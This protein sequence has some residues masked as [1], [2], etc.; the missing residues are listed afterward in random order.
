MLVCHSLPWS[1]KH[2]QNTPCHNSLAV[3]SFLMKY[4]LATIFSRSDFGC[5]MAHP[6][7]QDRVEGHCSASVKET[8]NTGPRTITEYLHRC[9][10]N[11]W[12]NCIRTP[13]PTQPPIQCVLGALSLVVEWWGHEAEQL[14]PTS[15]E[16]KKMRIYTSTSPYVFMVQCLLSK[17]QG[18]V[19]PFLLLL[20]TYSE[21]CFKGDCVQCPTHPF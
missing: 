4:H 5:L 13:G 8:Q 15:G 2:Q 21:Y 11:C 6:K 9:F 18:Q 19:Y 12:R 1:S 14:P 20:Y 3:K 17:V 10:Q 16:V 7:I